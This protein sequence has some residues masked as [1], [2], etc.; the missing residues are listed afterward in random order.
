MRNGRF[1]ALTGV[2]VLAGLATMGCSPSALRQEVPLE[3]TGSLST[4]EVEAGVPVQKTA[5]YPYDA[6][7]TIGNGSIAVNVEDISFTPAETDGGKARVTLQGGASTIVVNV[8]IAGEDGLAA[9][10][11]DGEAYGPFTVE[12]TDNVP[13]SVSPRTVELSD[14][15]I[16][17]LNGGTIS[18]C[19]EVTAQQAGTVTIDKL[20]LDLG[21]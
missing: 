20:V 2:S 1:F 19:V 3:L 14:S 21:L 18:L 5:T 11:D 8:R 4:F 13:V 7:V 6:P 10:C 15:T 12:L 16:D 9:V 17:L